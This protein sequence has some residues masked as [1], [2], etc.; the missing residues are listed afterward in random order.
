MVGI[1][2]WRKKDCSWLRRSRQSNA[3]RHA[4]GIPS[5]TL[6]IIVTVP[7]FENGEV[8]PVG[9]V[10]VAVMSC[11]TGTVLASPALKLIVPPLPVVVLIA[12]RNVFPCALLPAGFAKNSMRKVLLGRLAR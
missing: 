5:P 11:P 2:M 9:S 12:P 6:S 3:A 10:A 8:F 4:L 1:D 7:A